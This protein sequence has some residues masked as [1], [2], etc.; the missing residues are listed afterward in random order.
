VLRL[1]EEN[2]VPHPDRDAKFTGIF[3]AVPPARADRVVKSPPRAPRANVMP[4][5]GTD[6]TVPAGQAKVVT[7]EDP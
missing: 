1:A 2:P 7:F 5:A 4:N 6:G 3:D